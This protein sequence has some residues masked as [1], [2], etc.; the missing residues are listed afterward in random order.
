MLMHGAAILDFEVGVG[1]GL[2][3]FGNPTSGGVPVEISDW[4]LRNSDF[5]V[6]TEALGAFAAPC[7]HY[8]C[9]YS[10]PELLTHTYC[11]HQ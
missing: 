5:W 7:V 6:Q 10:G 1:E 9:M 3:A 4:E 11:Y 8:M 2:P